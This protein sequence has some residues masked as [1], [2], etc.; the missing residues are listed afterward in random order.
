MIAMGSF[1]GVEVNEQ[2]ATVR[3]DRN[4]LAV[5]PWN[6]EMYSE[7]SCTVELLERRHGELP[8]KQIVFLLDCTIEQREWPCSL[9]RELS[10]GDQ[11]AKLLNRIQALP[12]PTTAVLRGKC[13]RIPLAIAIACRRRVITAAGP[14]MIAFPE[15][16]EGTFLYGGTVMRLLRLCGLSTVRMLTSSKT[17]TAKEALAVGIVNDVIP[18][19]DSPLPDWTD[20]PPKKSSR[21]EWETELDQTEAELRKRYRGRLLPAHSAVISV[22][23]EGSSEL[24]GGGQTAERELFNRVMASKTRRAL[25]HFRAIERE[26]APQTR[27]GVPF[28]K[29]AVIGFGTMGQGIVCCMLKELRLPVVVKDTPE[30]LSAGIQRLRTLFS[31][32]RGKGRLDAEPDELLKMLIPVSEYDEQFVDVDLVIEAIVENLS[33]KRQMFDQLCRYLPDSSLVASNT[34]GLSLTEIAKHLPHPERFGGLHFFSPVWR[35]SLVEVVRTTRTSEDTFRKFLL[36]AHGMK[37]RALPCRDN[38]AFVVN[39]VLAPFTKTAFRCLEEGSTIEEVDR[40]ML[41]FGFPVGPIKLVDECGIDVIYHIWKNR[42]DENVTLERMF[43]AGY[44]GAKKN[45]RGFYG[46]DGQVNP[47]AER[48][49]YKHASKQRS[50]EEILNSLLAEQAIV[51]HDLLANGVVRSPMLIDMGMIYA[52]GYPSD[53]GGPLKWADLTGLSAK[54][55]GRPFYPDEL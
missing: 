34:S 44:Y 29:L 7:L 13:G 41:S 42:G 31:E 45:G 48:M 14:S 33:A 5:H 18:E 6:E 43:N 30:A 36:F 22:L 35:M 55:F 51:A 26:T 54:L 9:E 17:L 2:T 37:M 3:F 1:V 50:A 39:A 32:M 8:L 38:P 47:E 20:V 4:R 12:V 11:C 52:T 40:A 15:A 25:E 19:L 23:K 10:L 24:T 46:L 53:R 27:V 16:E 28:R 49:V 21:Q